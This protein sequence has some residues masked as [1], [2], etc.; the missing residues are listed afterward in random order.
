MVWIGRKC[1]T[2]TLI[3]GIFGYREDTFPI[4]YLGVP[5]RL[6]ILKNVDLRPLFDKL[7]QRLEGW[8]DKALSLGGKLILVNSVLLASP[9]YLMSFFILP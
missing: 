3:I 8:R 4:K 2:S 6:G 7:E 9:V 5:I 1:L